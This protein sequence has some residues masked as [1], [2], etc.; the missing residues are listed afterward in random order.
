MLVF[1]YFIV[2]YLKSIKEWNVIT[3]LPCCWG[4]G[5]VRNIYLIFHHSSSLLCK[6]LH[7]MHMHYS[8]LLPPTH[9]HRERERERERGREMGREGGRMTYLQIYTNSR[10]KN[11]KPQRKKPAW[12]ASEKN[13]EL[14]D[15]ISA[16]YWFIDQCNSKTYPPDLMN[17]L[18]YCGCVPV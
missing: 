8:A 10:N 6:C 15:E 5:Q 4:V 3:R 7:K 1:L 11:K 18:C 14:F 17:C 9:T 12:I 2:K 16:T 13:K